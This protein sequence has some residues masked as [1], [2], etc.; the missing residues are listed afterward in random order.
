MP[1]AQFRVQIED[2]EIL[3]FPQFKGCGKF[4]PRFSRKPN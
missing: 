3:I 2:P 1:A 4:K